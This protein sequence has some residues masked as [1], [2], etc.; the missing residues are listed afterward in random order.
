MG[1][2]HNMRHRKTSLKRRKLHRMTR[3]RVLEHSNKW[4]VPRHVRS[5]LSCQTKV[6][7]FIYVVHGPKSSG[8]SV[9]TERINIPFA[10]GGRSVPAINVATGQTLCSKGQ[11]CRHRVYYMLS[12]P[13]FQWLHPSSILS[14]LERLS[15]RLINHCN[16]SA[17]CNWGSLYRVKFSSRPTARRSPRR[18]AGRAA[19]GENY[20]EITIKM[21]KSCVGLTDRSFDGRRRCCGTW[22]TRL[23]RRMGMKTRCF[24]N[25]Y[26]QSGILV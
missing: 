14:S 21:N 16:S 20:I 18:R 9:L 22:L 7:G 3:A 15:S 24:F 19:T 4:K 10:R 11:S 8:S 2:T 23:T 26:L 5:D 12:H 13:H 25:C 6:F 17:K 1:C